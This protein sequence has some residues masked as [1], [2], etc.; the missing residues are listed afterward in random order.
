MRLKLDKPFGPDLIV[1][2]TRPKKATTLDL[3]TPKTKE[4]VNL[5][6]KLA[7]SLWW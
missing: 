6:P 4:I 7:K 5:T 3:N 2:D 1:T